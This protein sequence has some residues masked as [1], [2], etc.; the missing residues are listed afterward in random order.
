MSLS[1]YGSTAE[2]HIDHVPLRSPTAGEVV[3]NLDVIDI[4]KKLFCGVVTVFDDLLEKDVQP[5]TESHQPSV[6]GSS[7]L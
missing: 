1:F 3:L 7:K 2:P 4:D 5:F 6:A